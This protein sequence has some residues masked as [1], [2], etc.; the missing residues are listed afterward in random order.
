MTSGH[1]VQILTNCQLGHVFLAMGQSNM[2]LPLRLLDQQE[3]IIS[4]IDKNA[5]ISFLLIDDAYVTSGI[6]ERPLKTDK[7]F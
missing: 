7:N 1:S 5:N 3:E 4:T 2:R 6:V